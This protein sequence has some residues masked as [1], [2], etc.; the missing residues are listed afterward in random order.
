MQYQV[1]ND[2]CYNLYCTIK[3]LWKFS[4]K[5]GFQAHFQGK[6]CGSLLNHNHKE[7]FHKTCKFKFGNKKPEKEIKRHEKQEKYEE[8]S[9]SKGKSASCTNIVE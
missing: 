2:I 5:T 9:S 4:Q 1:V 6:R 8:Q 7:K 3:K